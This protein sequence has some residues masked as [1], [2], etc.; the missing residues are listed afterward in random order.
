MLRSVSRHSKPDRR[1]GVNMPRGSSEKPRTT[2]KL[3]S[4]WKPVKQ[5]SR[6]KVAVRGGPGSA[7]DPAIHQVHRSAALPHIQTSI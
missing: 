7:P 6:C 4:R 2:V 5:S 1:E 3:N